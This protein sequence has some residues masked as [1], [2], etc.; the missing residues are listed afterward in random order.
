MWQL[1]DEPGW[2]F[3]NYQLFLIPNSKGLTNSRSKIVQLF[4]LI[5]LW[6]L[7]P[8]I[9]MMWPTSQKKFKTST[10]FINKDLPSCLEFKFKRKM[11]IRM[12]T[13][14][15]IQKIYDHFSKLTRSKVKICIHFYHCTKQQIEQLVKW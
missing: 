5:K 15:Y 7:W 14:K 13:S 9:S 11:R 3:T 4:N 8:V 6:P 10:Q 1:V 12:W 2:D